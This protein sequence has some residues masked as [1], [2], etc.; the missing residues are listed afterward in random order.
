M[1]LVQGACDSRRREIC[2]AVRPSATPQH[3]ID[4]GSAWAVEEVPSESLPGWPPRTA[5]PPPP[6]ALPPSLLIGSTAAA[7][8]ASGGELAAA[9]VEA[10]AGDE[11]GVTSWMEAVPSASPLPSASLACA[12]ICGFEF[13]PTFARFV[14]ARAPN[15][16]AVICRLASCAFCFHAFAR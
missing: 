8:V 16:S 11:D 2:G 9:G 3:A 10:A 13:T 5:P 1:Y 12:S 4:N 15:I 7:A 6:L 14:E